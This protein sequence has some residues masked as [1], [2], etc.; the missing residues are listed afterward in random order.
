MDTKIWNDLMKF[1]NDRNGVTAANESINE[2][3]QKY[4]CS[5]PNVPTNYIT[6]PN[7]DSFGIMSNTNG[8]TP[9]GILI[10]EMI[11]KNNW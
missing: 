4:D 8:P 5:I 6:E 11:K 3:N 2:F 10:D 1:Q 9:N 7:Y